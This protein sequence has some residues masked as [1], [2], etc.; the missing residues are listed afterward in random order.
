MGLVTC[1]GLSELVLTAFSGIYLKEATGVGLR[2]IGVSKSVLITLVSLNLVVSAASALGILNLLVL[3]IWLRGC[4][5]M[6]TYEYILARRKKNE[7][8]T[9]QNSEVHYSLSHIPLVRVST[10]TN[11]DPKTSP[12][13]S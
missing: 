9:Q 6:T 1:L 5:H 12:T 2:D 13:I 3:N 11:E 7:R 10:I 8:Y 4:K